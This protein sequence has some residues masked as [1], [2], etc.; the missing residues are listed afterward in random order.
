MKQLQSCQLQQIAVTGS[1]VPN[2]LAAV[3]NFFCYISI[4]GPELFSMTVFENSLSLLYSGLKCIGVAFT[5]FQFQ[6]RSLMNA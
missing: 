6:I 5:A 4:T 1:T 3:N 2:N